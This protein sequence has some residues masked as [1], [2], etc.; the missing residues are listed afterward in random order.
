MIAPTK[1]DIIN[2]LPDATIQQIAAGEVI[3]RPANAVKELVENSI[4]AGAHN[5]RVIIEQGG[6]KSIEVIDNGHGIAKH[7][8]AL[9]C[10]RYATSKL[11]TAND[12]YS[13]STFGFRGEALSSISEVADIDVKSFNKQADNMGWHGRYKHGILIAPPEEKFVEQPGTQI[14][15]TELFSDTQ[16]RK[17][18]LMSSFYDEKKAITELITKLAI[19][20]R[21][22][23]TFVL[24]E[25]ASSELVCSLAPVEMGSC[26][27][28]FYGVDMEANLMEIALNHDATYKTDIH[29][30]FTYKKSSGSTLHQNT[31]ILFVNDRL[32]DCDELK[33]EVGALILE[34]F[35]NKQYVSLIYIALTVP[36]CDVDVNTHPA[37]ATV[38]LHYQQEIIGLILRTLRVKFSEELSSSVV[39]SKGIQKTISE[40]IQ[41]SSSTQPQAPISSLRVNEQRLKQLAPNC[42]TQNA[43]TTTFQKRP[44]E[45]VHNDSSQPTIYS[46]Q[47]RIPPSRNRRD[48]RLHSISSLRDKIFSEKTSDPASIQVIKGS[49][50][51]GIFDHNRALIQHETKLYAINLKSFV[52]EYVYQNYIVDFGNFPP[53]EILPPGNKIHFMIDTHL[54]HLR[55]HEP[56]AIDKLTFKT[57]DAIIDELMTHTTMFE[58]YL[59]LKITFRE[60][61]TIPAIILEHVPNLVYLGEFLVRLANDVD[62]K[63]E[64]DCFQQIGRILADFYSQPPANMKDMRVHKRYHQFVEVRLYESIRRFLILPDWLLTM[65]NICQISDTKDLYKVFERC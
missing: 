4:D 51:V 56:S 55:N 25:R 50:F 19:H 49:V 40:L 61:N 31:M 22:K 37:K 58:D 63:C 17:N 6:S 28:N 14:K 15:V 59:T 48:L 26:I 62:Y 23:I 3:T 39:P 52:K 21:N 34:F 2:R 42:L 60:V 65:E 10:Q 46:Q 11:R 57:A 8:A 7:N 54:K 13:I 64:R 20:H 41:H 44:Y 32:V 36:S 18:Y 27:G 35:G 47:S 9:L 33:R 24:N 1:H 45:Q 38:T 53:I 16:P 30:A 12:L 43:S 5:I 29:M